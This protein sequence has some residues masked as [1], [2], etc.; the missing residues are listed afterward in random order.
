MISRVVAQMIAYPF[1]EPPQIASPL[2]VAPSVNWVRLP[3][4]SPLDAINIWI[5]EDQDGWAVIDTGLNT[6]A[7]RAAW[8]SLEGKFFSGRPVSRVFLTHMHADHSGMAGWLAKKYQCRLWMTRLEYLTCR[9][10]NLAASQEIPEEAVNFYRDSGWSEAELGGYRSLYRMFCNLTR[11][12]PD[13]YRRITDGDTFPIGSYEWCVIGTSGH[14]R[15]HASFYCR[16]LKVLISGDQVLPTISSNIPVFHDEPEANPIKEWLE[17]LLKLKRDIPND[18]LVL[19][20][21]GQP[22]FGLHERLDALYLSQVRS[23]ARAR[24]ALRRPQRIVDLFEAIFSRA[25]SDDPMERW[26]ATGET[27][28]TLNYLTYSGEVVAE[29]DDAGVLWFRC[30]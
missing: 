13:S 26:L 24:E 15:E 30:T 12:V 29:R 28:A 17:S 6:D 20:A 11:P 25:I 21:H 23:C 7:T 19:P 2:N 18:V 1:S 5:I 8:K 4:P 9:L 3:L 14:S 10:L 27:R 16:E 22:F